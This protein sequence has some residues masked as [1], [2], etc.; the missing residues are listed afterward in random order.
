M[1]TF[2]MK[3]NTLITKA[4]SITI[5]LWAFF[6][7]AAQEAKMTASAPGTVG[8][9][10]P[11]QVTFSVNAKPKDFRPP[12][13][14]NF[15][16][17]GGPFQSQS[18]STSFINGQRTSSMNVSFTYQL[19]CDREG[20]FRIDP[21]TCIVDGTTLT[22]NALTIT[23]DKSA[24]SQQQSRGGNQG[25]WTQQQ[26]RQNEP[27][28]VNSNS[29][30]V[31]AKANKSSVYQGEE[32][33]ITYSIYSQVQVRQFQIDKLPSNK[34]FWSE[35]LTDNSQQVQQHEEIIDGKRYAVYP[36]HKIALYPQET[37]TLTL[38]PI[39]T[40]VSAIVE[41]NNSRRRSSGSIFDIF[42]DPFFS[43]GGYQVVNKTLKSNSLS[44]N[45]K[46]LP[47]EPTN[48]SGA[49]GDFS[50]KSKTDTKKLKAN[51]ALTYTLT[52]SGSGNL[53][54]IDDVKV[55]FPS[56]FEAY[57][58][59]VNSHLNRSS[60]G[61]SGSRTFEWVLI[62]REQG[63][64]EIPSAEFVYFNPK[65]KSFVT[66][67]TEK[68]TIEVDKGDGNAVS[69][70]AKNDVKILNSDIE[71]IK[72]GNTRL[73]PA[74]SH[75]FGSA[76]FWILS[77]LPILLTIALF[78][79]MRK[80]IAM[81]ADVDALNLR[82]ATSKAKKR[83]RKAEKHLL[84]GDDENFYIEIYQAIW[85]YVSDKFTIP[86]SQLSGE[87]IQENLENRNVAEDVKTKI[88]QTIE[89][90]DFAR[91]APGNSTEKMQSIYEQTLQM[92]LDLEKQLK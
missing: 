13:F 84:T 91:F 60:S 19:S 51:E 65:S 52:I 67:S 70:V 88:M 72:T 32:V 35:D 86:V 87:T 14:K 79:A 73:Q 15:N 78:V 45:V 85:G 23:V 9:G 50:V 33:I 36:I 81:R 89:D 29:L 59:K 38:S 20:S 11:F 2:K 37:G 69:S 56:T 27:V 46:P 57:D 26:T 41:V 58:P 24:Q 39:N 10:Q 31:R 92:I 75:F 6:S 54:L 21:A 16:Y 55:D 82:R 4:L 90:V 42:D 43:G 76:A 30:F 17:L 28:S 34:G 8:V 48:F 63:K 3:H 40:E 12:T 83:L 49:V 66:K 18:S 5:M 71:Y 7:A 44:I 62:P 77:I 68:F 64:Y 53:M 80:V 25:G 22:S 61:I 47:N 1:N 74:G